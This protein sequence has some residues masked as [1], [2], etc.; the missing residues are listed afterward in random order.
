MRLPIGIC[1]VL[2]AIGSVAVAQQV[3]EQP[4]PGGSA[5]GGRA[6]CNRGLEEIAPVDPL[7]FH[8]RSPATGT[9]A[10]MSVLWVSMRC[11]PWAGKTRF[12]RGYLWQIVAEVEPHGDRGI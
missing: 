6:A 8:G 3:A 7:L 2:G 11:L 12:G 5:A 4:T 1:I 9:K 10:R